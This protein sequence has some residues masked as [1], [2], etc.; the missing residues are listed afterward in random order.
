MRK[1][2]RI[3]LIA[4][5]LV[6]LFGLNSCS[7]TSLISSWEN[8]KFKG[9]QINSFAVVSMLG[10][11][12][13]NTAFS[14]GVIEAFGKEDIKVEDGSTMLDLKKKYKN[15]EEFEEAMKKL[16]VGAVM[17]FR[18]LG[19]QK[20]KT[21]TP[22]SPD[23]G[24]YGYWGGGPY[25]YYFPQPYAYYYWYPSWRLSQS[26]GYWTET[27]TYQ[28][29]VAIYTCQEDRLVYTA[30]TDTIEPTGS[31]QLGQSIGK[32]VVKDLMKLGI[33]PGGKKKKKKK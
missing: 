20:N 6:L 22:P 12:L 28:I 33:V 32:K 5:S 16:D 19:L 4:F 25:G 10:K 8:S 15:N 17:F 1:I 31:V 26:P 13:D 21:Y 3:G 30:R 18:L 14:Q 29:E 23:F 2:H 9:T 27:K 24:P 7:N 11:R